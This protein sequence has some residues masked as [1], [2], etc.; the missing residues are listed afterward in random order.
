[1]TDGYSAILQSL[2]IDSDA[3]RCTDFVHSSVTL[4]DGTCIIIGTL[5]V[6]GKRSVDFLRLFAVVLLL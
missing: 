1:M 2:I 6:I 3:V 5:E 4:A